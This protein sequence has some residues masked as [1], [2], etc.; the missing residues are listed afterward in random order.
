MEDEINW[1]ALSTSDLKAVSEGKWDEV[2]TPGLRV[3][4]GEEYGTGETLARGFERGVTSTFRGISQLFGNDL[5]FYNRA[6]GY[7][8][9]LDKEQEF[10]AMMD[11]NTGAA[12]TGV[13]A[14]SIADPTNLLPLTRASTVKQFIAQGTGVGAAAGAIEPTYEGEFEDSRLQNIAFGAAVGGGVGAG[15]GAL[16][17][18]LN[19]GVSSEIAE[20]ASA[21]IDSAA[22]EPSVKPRYRGVVDPDTGEVSYR[23]VDPVEA[24]QEAPVPTQSVDVEMAQVGRNVFDVNSLPKLPNYLGGAAPKFANSE[25]GFET[26]IDKALYIVGKATNKSARHD[27]YVQ[28]LQ[29]ALNKTEQEVV[30]LGRKVRQEVIEAGKLAQREAALKNQV[31]DRINF[32]LS[33]TLDN[34]V[35]PIDK[36]LDEISKLVYNYGRD[37]PVSATNK[38]LIRAGDARID[39]L[40]AIMKSIDQNYSKQDAVF[41]AKGYSM[42]LQKLKD[43]DGKNFTARSFDDFVKNKTNNNDLMIKLY[44]AGEFD[45]C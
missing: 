21:A 1:G 44:N 9:D 4:A 12:I 34:V 45:G 31:A 36:N 37:L 13:L 6:F 29:Q 27:E 11:L 18:Y 20:D 38:P 41:A 19:R 39:Q 5:D 3:L 8:T 42:M 17:R 24:V 2:S 40:E 7:Q 30:D 43:V 15:I 33:K 16:M 32:G 25:I 28:Y 10:R 26:D 14:G 22:V 23:L 35:N